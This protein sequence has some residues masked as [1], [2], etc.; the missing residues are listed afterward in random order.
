MRLLALTFLVCFCAASAL[1]QD[2][3]EPQPV[4]TTQDGSNAGDSDQTPNAPGQPQTQPQ[5]QH[6]AATTYSNGYEV[7]LKIHKYASFATLPLFAGELALGQSLYNNP[8]NG[9]RKTAHGIVG[10]GIVGL[11]AANSV[12]GI[13][14]LW[15]SRQDPNGRKLRILHSTLMLAANGGFVAAWATAPS[16]HRGLPLT[17]N[18]ATHRD[19]A[20][21]SISVG[22][23]GYLLMLFRGK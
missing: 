16:S 12:T 4:D 2:S 22:T 21:A 6:P 9:A 14:N 13:W 8:E 5:A 19:I 20:V 17:A 3:Q 7:R 15:E 18:K 23:V 11:F 1:A 10:A